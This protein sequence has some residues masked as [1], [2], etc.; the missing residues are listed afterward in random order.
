MIRLES[1][2]DSTFA[3]YSNECPIS[4]WTGMTVNANGT[5]ITISWESE[6]GTIYGGTLDVVNGVLTVT[7]GFIQ[8]YSGETLPSA[9]ISD[10]DVYAD[11]ATPTTG[12]EVCY[13]LATPI[14]Y[15]LTPQ[16][17]TSL[18]GANNLWAYTG[19]SEVEYRADTK[20]YI[21]K[22]ITEAVSALS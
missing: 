3:P 13:D 21:T 9:W 11:G 12:A 19:D 16:E 18:L 14:T 7:K 1:E 8:S 10:R 22:K 4:G 5:E 17:I 6:A 2:A 15:Q 20:L